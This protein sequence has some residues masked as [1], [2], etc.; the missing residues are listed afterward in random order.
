MK[1]GSLRWLTQ[2]VSI[3]PYSGSNEYGESTYGS[4]VTYDARV[5]MTQ[6]VLVDDKGN[7]RLSSCQIYLDGSCPV[8]SIS[9]IT[10]SDGTSPLILDVKTVYGS[11][12]SA[13]MKV[14][15]T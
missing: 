11:E 14:V 4:A 3:A 5:V 10:L 8:T 12:G 2:T 6:K 15:S 13:Y 9:K 7:K 1:S